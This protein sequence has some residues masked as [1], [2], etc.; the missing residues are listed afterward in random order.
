MK[1][2]ILEFGYEYEDEHT[3]IGVFSSREKAELHSKL[4][5]ECDRHY[6]IDEYELDGTD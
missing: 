6:F 5:G 3:V 4:T 2:Y 1:V